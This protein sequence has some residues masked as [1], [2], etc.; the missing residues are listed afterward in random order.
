MKNLLI[1][2]HTPSINTESLADALQSSAGDTEIQLATKRL[3]PFDTYSKDLIQADGILLFTTENFGYMSGALKDMFDRTYYDILDQTRGK[4][5]ALAI[6]AGKDGTGTARAV[7]SIT[8]GLGW[9]KSL[10][11]LTMRGDYQ[12][13]FVPRI[14][15]FGKTFALGLETGIY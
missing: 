13:S 3:S 14:S 2:A 4:P 8:T 7:D 9:S 15:E 11:T 1:I 12:S 10:A 6:R 5:F